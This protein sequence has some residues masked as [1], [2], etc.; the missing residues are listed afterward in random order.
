MVASFHHHD[1]S[2]VLPFVVPTPYEVR[3]YFMEPMSL[4]CN[5]NILQDMDRTPLGAVTIIGAGGSTSVALANIAT[6][7]A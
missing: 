1:D 3:H 7:G 2:T 6:S 4:A 5:V